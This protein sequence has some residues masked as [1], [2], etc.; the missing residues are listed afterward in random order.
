MSF[1]DKPIA[2]LGGISAQR[3]KLLETELQ[4]HS[5]QDLLFYFP[6]RYID[7]STFTDTAQLE[8]HIGEYVL[9]KGFIVS[10]EYV[11]K[12]YHTQNARLEA[13]FVTAKQQSIKLCWFQ[14]GMWIE[15]KLKVGVPFVCFGKLN[16][17]QREL[18]I[19]HPELEPFGVW[20]NNPHKWESVYPITEKL[21]Q[22]KILSPTIQRLQQTLAKELTNISLPENLPRYILTD[23]SLLSRK[24]CLLEIHNPSSNEKLHQAKYRLKFEEVF[25]F[26]LQLTHLHAKRSDQKKGPLFTKVGT[27]FNTFYHALPFPLTDAQKR[28]L[29][30]IRNDCRT[31]KAMHRLLQG[32]VGSG[33]TI[34]ALMSMLMAIDNSYQACLVAPTE[35][36]AQQH[37]ETI[38]ESCASLPIRIALLSGSTPQSQRKKLHH[39]L[40]TGDI[41]ILIGTHALFETS[42]QF[43]N[44]GL[45][46]IDE[47]HRFGVEQ[48]AKML[49]KNNPQPHA[50]IMTATPIPRTLALTLHSDLD[51]SLIDEMPKGR[52]P[53]KTIHVWD[54]QRILA[55]Q[56]IQEEINKGRQAYI[57]F[58]LIEESEKLNY[59]DLMSGYEQVKDFFSKDGLDISLVH[60]RMPKE[61]KDANMQR[62]VKNETHIMVATTVVEVGVNVPN[63]SVML[64][65]SSEKFGLS[66]LHQLRGRVGRSSH[67]S[68]CILMTASSISDTSKQRI[69][70]MVQTNDGFTIAEKDLELRGP[71]DIQGTRQS[72]DL[73]FKILDPIRDTELILKSKNLVGNIIRHDPLLTHPANQPLAQ[74]IAERTAHKASWI[75][76]G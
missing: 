23:L 38:A 14:G 60:G 39:D 52:K 59:E 43:S 61:L 46:V 2:Y 9:L 8:K 3:A 49:Y 72:G 10:Y 53:I 74:Y 48:R 16:I 71:G 11:G 33:K 24:E 30:E 40:M 50:L 17:F 67:Q 7:K 25:W 76:I 65:E 51:Y 22:R 27:L 56:L 54:H 58:P 55:Y 19:S 69:N 41:H 13:S 28:V 37:Y 21:R 29:K 15:K 42:V 73:H 44:L 45:I 47:Q 18:Q 6:Y 1:L 57:I 36:L 34:V 63:A 62:F 32:D 35:V 4:I 75:D 64:I 5:L 66:Q 68:Y 20:Q 12:A 70:I 31:G 26:Q